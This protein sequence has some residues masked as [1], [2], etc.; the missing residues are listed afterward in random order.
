MLMANFPLRGARISMILE[1][2]VSDVLKFWFAES[3]PDRWFKKDPAFDE[4]VRRRF[5]ALHEALA[6]SAT[7][8]LVADAHKAL[9]TVIVFDQMSRN[10]FRDTPRAF[11]TDRQAVSVAQ[12]A[13]A[14]GYD[15][16]LTKD[17]RMFLYLPFEHSEDRGA[18]ARCV[19]LIAAL[20]DPELTNLCGS[21]PKDHRPVWPLPASQ[22]RSRANFD[23]RGN[24][25]P[26]TLGQ[27]VLIVSNAIFLAKSDSSSRSAL[28]FKGSRACPRGQV[29]HSYRA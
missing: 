25:V 19:T 15:V 13:V 21:P 7:D 14:R 9:A 22:W 6:S 23:P 20:N 10:M 1:G 4:T 27:L 8:A 26:E 29:E 2:W 24:G 28:A 3:G 16:A 12:E 17:E 11:A 5:L 18:Q